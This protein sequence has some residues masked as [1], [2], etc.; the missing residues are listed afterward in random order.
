MILH[1]TISPAEDKKQGAGG[2]RTSRR[3]ASRPLLALGLAL[4][5]GA[6][7][8]IRALPPPRPR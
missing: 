8:S 3:R 5:A 1:H 4:V 6:G 2:T 7:L